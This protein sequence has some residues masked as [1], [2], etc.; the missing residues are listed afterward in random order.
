[1]WALLSDGETTDGVQHGAIERLAR[2]RVPVDAARTPLVTANA[3]ISAGWTGTRATA[4]QAHPLV[5][6]G[7]VFFAHVGGFLFGVITAEVLMSVGDLG[8]RTTTPLSVHQPEAHAAQVTAWLARKGR[9]GLSGDWVACPVS[10]SQWGQVRLT[11]SLP[12]E[13]IVAYGPHGPAAYVQSRAIASCR[14]V[15]TGKVR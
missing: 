8:R 4:H 10:P 15:G 9:F 2:T 6:G 5:G 14:S 12:G 11:N 13:R 1:L 7:V 3:C